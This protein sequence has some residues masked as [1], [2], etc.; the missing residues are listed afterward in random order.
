MSTRLD[1][2]AFAPLRRRAA[3]I[4]RIAALALALALALQAGA[5][6]A[7]TAIVRVFDGDA[8]PVADA[9]VF[10]MPADASVTLPANGSLTA[11]MDQVAYQFVPRVLVVR[12]GTDVTFPNSDNVRHHVYSFS[13]AKRFEL[14]L[15]AGTVHPSVR[16]DRAGLVTLGCNIHDDMVGYVLVVDTP[17]FGKTDAAGR[18]RLEGVPAG[19]YDATVWSSRQRDTTELQHT[20]IVLGAPEHGVDLA[21]TLAARLRP[22]PPERQAG[23]LWKSY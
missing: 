19:R 12:T 3:P 23:S 1:Y 13:E 11:V 5:A 15:Y 16:F 4:L 6:G 20:A 8:N 2:G 9:A 14:P 10:L 21:V 22:L 18:V 7:E 17:Y